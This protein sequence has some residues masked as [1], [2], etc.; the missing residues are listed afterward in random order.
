MRCLHCQNNYKNV[1]LKNLFRE[2]KLISSNY[3]VIKEG[4][5][6][7]ICN[8]CGLVQKVLNKKYKKQI[9]KIYSNYNKIFL[10]EASDQFNL[11]KKKFRSD[12]LINFLRNKIG[13]NKNKTFL[14]YGCGKGAISTSLIKNYKKIFCYDLENN[15]ATKIKKKVIF[16]NHEDVLKNKFDVVF[17]SHVF[18][19]LTNPLNELKIF[20][21]IVSRNGFLIIQ[22]PN[23]ENNIFDLVIYDHCVHLRDF[24]LKNFFLSSGFKICE[25]QKKLFDKELILIL[26]KKN[27]FYKTKK[28]FKKK[29]ILIN[30]CVDKI[31]NLIRDIQSDPN[32]ILYGASLISLFILCNLKKG[33]EKIKVID[34]NNELFNKK[35]FNIKI[36]KFKS[37][38]LKKKIYLL[39]SKKINKKITNKFNIKKKRRVDIYT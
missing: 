18:E 15:L 3:R 6:L 25:I 23:F 28:S 4:F 11:E 32:V 26:K 30:R 34:D 1:I 27:K 29:K 2:K 7:F 8:K 13:L 5:D 20:E 33:L 21:K 17:L 12:I 22:V 10:S 14:D 35:I 38:Y 16:L 31:N 37:E 19:H 24:N 36:S 39:I 9:R